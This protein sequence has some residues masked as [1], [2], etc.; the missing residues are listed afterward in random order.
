MSDMTLRLASL[1]GLGLMVGLAW[2]CSENR[3]RF[4]LRIVAWGIGLQFAFALL[5]LRT[6]FGRAFFDGVKRAFDVITEA[7][8]AG[9]RFVFGNLYRVFIIDKVTV[10]GAQ[11][12]ESADNFAVS[13]VLAFHVLPVI[14]FVS[15]LAAILQHFGIIQAVVRAMAWLMRRTLKTS[16]AETFGTALLVFLGIES[17]SALG[18]YLKTMTRSEMFTIMTAFLATIAASVMVAY[19]GFGASP[20]HLL[21][22]SIM[23]APA[24][25]VMAKLL[26]PEMGNPETAG[27]VRIQIPV[28]SHSIFD[29]ASRGGALG[30]AMA[31]NVGAMLIVF[32]GL[33]FLLDYAVTGVTGHTTTELL[34]WLFRPFALAMGIAPRDVPE[35]GQLL[36]VKS[37]FNEF[38]A[39]E[40]LQPLIREQVI[41]PRSIMIA[42]YA[43]CGFANPGSL[44][45]M[46]GALA[47]LAPERRS[48][49]AALSIRAFL[50]GTLACFM[51]A[52]VA[53]VLG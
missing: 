7:S 28:E 32:V 12:P 29:A 52:C 39:Y 45:I 8:D 14:I 9:A 43:L 13:A 17:M 10:I 37:V 18:G 24:A 26:V 19:A 6:G 44:G 46:I 31:L 11:G 27:R 16:G 23:S 47:A 49:V 40:Q 15:A 1:V 33:I 34:G 48:E 51:T 5:V 35:V 42:T 25:L 21:A 53:G 4:S 30:L 3:S 20:G 2:L 22:A 50:G 38:L 36:A 41:S